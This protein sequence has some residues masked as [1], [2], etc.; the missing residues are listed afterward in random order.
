VVPELEV[1]GR[2]IS[3]G[4]MVHGTDQGVLLRAEVS[5]G[6][7]RLRPGQFVQAQIAVAGA[8][9]NFRVPSAA[10]LRSGGQSYVFAARSE[11]FLPVPVTVSSEQPGYQ[12][13]Q[14]ELPAGT[15]IAVSG[16]AAIKAAWSAEG[17]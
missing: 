4:R 14:T 2:V 6:T 3:V 8:G 12:V 15:A 5:E 16:T 9:N 13:I 7:E 11:G 17:E 10:V 1:Q